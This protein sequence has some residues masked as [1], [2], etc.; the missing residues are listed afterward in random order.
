MAS[1]KQF[2]WEDV[3]KGQGGGHMSEQGL[4]VLPRSPGEALEPARAPEPPRRRRTRHRVPSPRLRKLVGSL[5]G[6]LTFVLMTM[7]GLGFAFVLVKHLYDRPGPL[8]HSVVVVIPRGEGVNAIADRLVREGV[9]KERWLFTLG[10]M[11]FRAQRRLKAGEYEFP[12]RASV[13]QV[14]DTLVEG[15]A[16]LHKV[17]IPEGRTSYEVVEIL[18]RQPLLTGEI[19][20]IPP[21]G[22]LL[23]DT[24]RFSRGTDRQDLLARMA[25]QMRK[26]VDSLWP[27]RAKGLPFK[28]K[29]EAIILASIVEK[30]T[31]RADERARIAGVFI[32]RLKRGMRLQSDPTIIYGLTGGR[33]AL[34]R[35]IRRSE[36]AKK[37]P[38]NTYQIDGL[39]PTPIANPGRAAIEAVLHPA[40]TDEL[41]FVADGTGGHAFA[42]T[43]E[44]H[45]ANVRKWRQIERERQ[46]RAKLAA[47]KKTTATLANG[48]GNAGNEDAA[49]DSLLAVPGLAVV[50]GAEVTTTA[51]GAGGVERTVPVPVRKPARSN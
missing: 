21:E 44:E 39:P 50:G 23:P 42:T 3:A 43:L 10:V 7:I 29:R 22:S 28:T 25:D 51:A 17:T 36:I 14:L 8:E 4:G 13:R 32:N 15:R 20:E 12:K 18:A 27:G 37:T 9:L 33:G 49:T 45:Q 48:A 5:T 26:Y 19:K 24:Y 30:E 35:G 6:L 1:E 16:V 2:T 34:G 46:A 31:G 38:Y 41:Y 40:E 11:R 47:S